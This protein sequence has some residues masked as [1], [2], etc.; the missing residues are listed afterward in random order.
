MKI[1]EKIK[2]EKGPHYVVANPNLNKIYISNHK[3]N[4]ISVVDGSKNSIIKNIQVENPGKLILNSNTNEIFVISDQKWQTLGI[5]DRSKKTGIAHKLSIIDSTTDSIKRNWTEDNGFVDFGIN[6]KTNQIYASHPFEGSVSIID[7]TSGNESGRIQLGNKP[8]Y[9]VVN[10]GNSQVFVGDGEDKK[11]FEID[12]TNNSIKQEF[13]VPETGE[14]YLNPQREVLYILHREFFEYNEW[15][16]NEYD[17]L[18]AIDLKTKNLLKLIP[19]K[20]RSWLDKAFR[21]K[22][23]GRNNIAFDSSTDQVF[24]SN[25]KKNEIWIMKED[26]NRLDQIKISKFSN[27]SLAYNPIS[28]KMYLTSTGLMGNSLLVL[29]NSV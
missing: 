6:E 25:E 8:T 29:G 4:I 5:L 1:L 15:T 28:K 23:K 11:I 9:V 18:Y 12:G 2:I 24:F 21:E 7:I 22:D 13:E 16:T 3:S 10:S 17:R 20:K 27:P 26:L 14:L 19:E